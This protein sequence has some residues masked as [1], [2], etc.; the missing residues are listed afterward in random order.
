MRDPAFWWTEHS[1]AAAVLAPLGAC[2]G[3]IAA[4]NMARPGRKAPVPVIC[5]GNFTL[6]GA[7]KTPTA[8]ALARLLLESRHRPFFLS[9][10]YGGRVAGPVR[11]DP[12][13][14]E[15]GSASIHPPRPVGDGREGDV[16]D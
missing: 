13:P 15:S 3:A 7:G 11:I 14:R 16:G 6:G 1:A 4:R 12:L 2:Y 9:R 5:L 10:G 8:I